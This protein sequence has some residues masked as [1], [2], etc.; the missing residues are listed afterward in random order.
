MFLP[1]WFSFPVLQV[2]KVMGLSNSIHMVAWFITSVISVILPVTLLAI[3]L[4]YGH[5]MKYSDITIIWLYLFLFAVSCIGFSFLVSVFF[6]RANLA[7][8]CGGIFFFVAFF[9][10]MI[11]FIRQDSVTY[12]SKALGCLLSPSAF[13]FATQYVTYYE[14]QQT[15]LQWGNLAYSPLTDDPFNF[16]QCII[17]LTVD[18]CLYFLL[19]W[20]L[21]HVLPG[22]YNR[23]VLTV[24]NC[25]VTVSVPVLDLLS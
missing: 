7:A 16:Q 9:P 21:D 12:L 17:F 11:L 5:I 10:Y 15:G 4:K 22:Q 24:S 18:C 1:S 20:Y 14:Q 19:A 13:S 2:M 25:F 6:S 23:L 8:A 3:L